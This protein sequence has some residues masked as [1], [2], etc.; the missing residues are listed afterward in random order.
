MDHKRN[1]LILALA[2]V[3]YLLLLAW[4]DEFPT[5]AP[6]DTDQS[7]RAETLNL[8]DVPNATAD[9]TQDVPSVQ[10]SAQ[11]T[12]T[13]TAAVPAARLVTVATP[14][15]TVTIDLAGG[16]IVE[17]SLPRFPATLDAPEDPF[18]LLRNDSSMVYVAQ[19]GLVG[20]NGP[21]ASPDGRPRYQAAQTSYTLSE[22]ELNVDLT[23]TVNGVNI[24]KR[25]RFSAEDYLIG[26]NYLINNRSA[27][28]FAV[29]L[30]G[31][32]K[33]NASPDPS[34]AASGFGIRTFLGAVSTAPDDPYVK[35]KFGD[36]DDGVKSYSMNGGWIGFSQHYFLG[37]WIPSAN[38]TNTFSMRRNNA[39]EYL[40]GFVGPEYVV[41]PGQSAQLGASLW[42]GPK[43]QERLGQ[44][45]PNLEQTIDYGKFWFVAYPVFWLL[46]RIYE[47]VGN[48]GVA[49]ILLTVV[50]RTLFLP[51]SAKQYNSQAKMKK[52]QP[53]INQLKERYGE[54]KQKFVQAQMELWRKEKV[55]PFSGC[56]PV[57]LQMPVFFGIYW[58][59]NESVELR[60]AP[61]I[62][63]YRDLSMMDSYFVLPL[64]LG[65]AY[66]LQQHMTPMPTTDPTQ[67]KLM[68][69]MPVMFTGFFLWF[70]AGLVL[71]YL[72]NALLGIMQQWYFTTKLEMQSAAKQS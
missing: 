36:I 48:F 72:V 28:P 49:I 22:G 27:A 21:D 69:W 25:Y 68:K 57:L 60:Q 46:T 4:N 29:N 3:S 32:I 16:D 6:I 31:Q 43:D 35:A 15:Q 17:V 52:L 62:L 24:T 14:V 58:V 44:I 33:R 66:Y 19:S 7:S 39:G 18:R 30:Y 38:D 34:N 55:N 13:N 45:A 61:F 12:A 42:A 8:N 53:K 47:L 1:L 63:W 51:L 40:M 9:A 54:D 50:I 41:A 10:S 20:Q 26:L 70:P 37:S 67:A 5:I 23:T 71:Y 56:L 2:V 64:L 65:G 59:L 11:A